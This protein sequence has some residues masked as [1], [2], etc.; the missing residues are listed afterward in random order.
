MK[1]IKSKK[2]LTEI[3]MKFA[4]KLSTM[5]GRKWEDVAAAV[6]NDIEAKGAENGG[7]SRV[8]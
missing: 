3:L 4:A 6:I 5:P 1:P 7:S 8:D 2:K